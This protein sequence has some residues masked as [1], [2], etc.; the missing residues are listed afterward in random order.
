MPGHT[1]EAEGGLGAECGP[2]AVE[3]DAQLRG[4]RTEAHPVD[5]SGGDWAVPL[6]LVPPLPGAA[7]VTAEIFYLGHDGIRTV[8]PDPARDVDVLTL[9]DIDRIRKMMDKAPVTGFYTLD[10]HAPLLTD[11]DIRHMFDVLDEAF[12]RQY[13]LATLALWNPDTA[14]V[15]YRK[16][17][18]EEMFRNPHQTE[19]LPDPEDAAVK[20]THTKPYWRRF[21][22]KRRA[23]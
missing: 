18:R 13:A 11:A 14:Q 23:R 4:L 5:P 22:K 20:K 6:S 2:D 10:C 12:T 17:S 7:G 3:S 8:T 21:E 19:K 15:E 1:S 16:I 9:A